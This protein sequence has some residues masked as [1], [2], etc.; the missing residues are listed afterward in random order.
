MN[1]L[2]LWD[3]FGIFLLKTV[4]QF[5]VLRYCWRASNQDYSID[6][7]REFTVYP[8]LSTYQLH[9]I[10]TFFQY[11]T[12][13]FGCYVQVRF[14]V[15]TSSETYHTSSFYTADYGNPA[16]IRNYNKTKFFFDEVL[17]RQTFERNLLKRP[18]T[19]KGHTDDAC[20]HSW[21]QESLFFLCDQ[22]HI[23][24]TFS[25]WCQKD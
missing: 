20:D 11:H 24:P 5:Q 18:D 6:E 19:Q 10:H 8:A 25:V 15:Y 17:C 12:I 23:I 7:C 9:H 13:S 1:N 22:H 3:S 14:C 21:S 4:V 2:K 16:T